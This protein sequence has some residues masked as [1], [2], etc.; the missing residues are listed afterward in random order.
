[1]TAIY[2]Q[3]QSTLVGD[4]DVMAMSRACATQIA[5]HAA[6]WWGRSPIPVIFIA[7]N[8]PVPP[9]AWLIGVMDDADQAGDLG[10]HTEEQGDVIYGRVF[11]RPVLD[12]GGTALTG[13]LS[14]SSVLSHECLET[15]VDPHVNMWAQ[16]GDGTM[17]ACEVGD[18]V[19]S[20]SYPISNVM[21]SNFVTPHW[22]DQQN[23]KERMDW[24][25]RTTG[26]FKMSK[27]GY[28]VTMKPGSQPQQVFGE[29]YPEWKKET[30]KI[31]VARSA[32]RLVT[33]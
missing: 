12:H 13:S 23:T 15:F 4:A 19:E 17:W 33:A 28:A 9:G 3:N 30:K 25:G 18:P 8:S 7:K 24:L 20:D 2:V 31:D 6:P 21:V 26:P 32:K 10:W 14:V 1:M 5:Y 16:A 29:E 22:F 27:G 11:A